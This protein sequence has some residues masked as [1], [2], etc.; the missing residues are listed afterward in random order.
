MLEKHLKHEVDPE[1]H[2]LLQAIQR[3][4]IKMDQLIEGLLA[5]A[6]AGHANRP[7]RS[8]DL[9]GVVQSVVESLAAMIETSGAQVIAESLP[10]VMSDPVVIE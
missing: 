1:V 9:G 7:M 10:T 5:Y 4:T 8:V 2:E 3:G 6:K